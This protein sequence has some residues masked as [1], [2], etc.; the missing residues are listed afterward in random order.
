MNGS[1]ILFKIKIIKIKMSKMSK[2]EKMQNNLEK[3]NP[4]QVFKKKYHLDPVM[5]EI[6]D[7]FI[8]YDDFIA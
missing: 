1:R 4:F 2:M 7:E 3:E 5:P 8:S 6:T